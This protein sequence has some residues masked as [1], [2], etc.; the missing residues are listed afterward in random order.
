MQNISITLEDWQQAALKELAH[1]RG[2][3]VET[4]ARSILN[5]RLIERIHT[6]FDDLV[7]GEPAA[8]VAEHPPFD[9]IE[10]RLRRL[11]EA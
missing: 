2:I 1:S 7:S 11:F 10:Q 5:E 6:S 3:E 9:T 4:L 8:L